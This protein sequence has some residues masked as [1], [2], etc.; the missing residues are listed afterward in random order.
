MNIWTL[1]K[2]RAIRVALLRLA[3]DFDM[4]ELALCC[5]DGWQAILICDRHRKG[6]SAYLYTYGQS[7][8]HYG[9]ELHYPSELEGATPHYNPLEEVELDRLI[10][11]LSM[12]FELT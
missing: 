5:G 1:P 8:H 9:L 12:H 10:E 6:L 7:Q 4:H 2:E 3:A 11:L